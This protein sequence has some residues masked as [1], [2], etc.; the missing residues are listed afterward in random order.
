MRGA[1]LQ[2]RKAVERALEYQVRQCD[3]RFERVADR[4]GQQAAALEP[5][6]RLQFPGPERVHEDEDPELFRLGPNRMEFR[7]G[8]LL[9][10]NAAAD[11][12]AA[13]PQFLDR[14][15][16]LLDGESGCCSATVAKATKRS[17]VAA[18]NSASFSF[19]ILISSAAA[20]RSA[21]YQ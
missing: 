8:Q 6:A 10:G 21:R 4:V 11:R 17:G 20:S 18:Q 19:W 5:A 15:V 7:V 14:V 2:S 1:D 9:P 13:Q 16:E 12:Q 3:R